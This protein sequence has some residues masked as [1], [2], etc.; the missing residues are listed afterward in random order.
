MDS[1]APVTKAE[2]AK[3]M[4]RR[5]PPTFCQPLHLRRQ[6]DAS[7]TLSMHS[8]RPMVVTVKWLAVLVNGSATIRRRIA[9]GSRPSRS[10][11]L[12]IWHSRAK[13][14]WGVPG[15][16]LGAAGRLVREDA[17]PLEPVDRH[18]VGHRVDG[19]GVEAGGDAVGAVSA[20]V[21]AGLEGAPEEVAARAEDGLEPHQRRVTAA[22]G[23]EDLLPREGD[24]HGPAGELREPAG[25]D[26]VG[27]RV[28]LAAGA[29]A[30]G[31]PR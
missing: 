14:G 16:A 12:S 2:Q 3:P 26:P 7:T 13:R 19:A 24:L 9:A 25:G 4:P 23:V 8:F 15:P 18:L 17:R 27:E 28:E 11:A 22:M 21:Q 6:S 20:A 30:H 31:R 5:L 10:A 1:P 29:P